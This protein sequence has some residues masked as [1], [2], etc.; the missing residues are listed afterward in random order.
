SIA[1]A[2]LTTI[3]TSTSSAAACSPQDQPRT[4]RRRSPH[5]RCAQPSTSETNYAGIGANDMPLGHLTAERRNFASRSVQ[6][7]DLRGYVWLL[8]YRN[9]LFF[10][11][12]DEQRY[13]A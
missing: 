5:W 10:F 2:V 4:L 6:A 1:T 7:A 3:R 12:I 13:R 11:D 9:R 8:S